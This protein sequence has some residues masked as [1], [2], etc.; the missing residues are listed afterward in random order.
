MG[1]PS[2]SPHPKSGPTLSTS[3]GLRNPPF[4]STGWYGSPVGPNAPMQATP[5]RCSLTLPKPMDV[6]V[7]AATR[8]LGLSHPHGGTAVPPNNAVAPEGT[9]GS[10]LLPIP[11]PRISR[12][13][14]V[15]VQSSS[16]S[17]SRVWTE[18]G[19]SP[20]LD[21]LREFEASPGESQ[22]N[23]SGATESSGGGIVCDNCQR[24]WVGRLWVYCGTGRDSA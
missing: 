23:N 14:G 20:R 9:N 11:L 12:Q 21:C 10:H 18:T 19:Q 2:R 16:P 8:A 1:V 24:T 6:G 15:A 7:K 5:P 4:S 17:L 3:T 13:R 22:G